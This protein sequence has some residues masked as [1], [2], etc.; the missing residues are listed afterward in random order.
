MQINFNVVLHSDRVDRAPEDGMKNKIT[1]WLEV[2]NSVGV[3]KER[4]REKFQNI[5]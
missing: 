5:I 4:R 1:K 2:T 3:A